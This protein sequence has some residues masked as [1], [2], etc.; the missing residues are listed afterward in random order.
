MHPSEY[1]KD[2]YA[3]TIHNAEL[4]RQKKFQEIDVAHIAEELESMGKSEKRELASRLAVLIAH[5]LKWQHQPARR[6]KSWKFTI[7]AQRIALLRLFNESPSLKYEINALA[8]SYEEAILFTA[9]E[10]GL[11]E[12]A[13]ADTCP[14]SL[15]ECLN[16]D[17]FPT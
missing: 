2:F 8:D 5:L 9:S 7:K 4:I 13:F 14:F 17:F 6:G 3:W 15:E 12:N 1:D 11:D 10:T 16:K